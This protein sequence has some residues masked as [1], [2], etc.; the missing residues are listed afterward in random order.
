MVKVYEPE[1]ENHDEIL[2]DFSSKGSAS[3]GLE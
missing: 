2:K 3:L 1:K